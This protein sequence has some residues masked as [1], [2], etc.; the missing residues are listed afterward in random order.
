MFIQWYKIITLSAILYVCNCLTNI[1]EKGWD[2]KF[3]YL[4]ALAA[5]PYIVGGYIY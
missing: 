5:V 4:V 3:M 1:L 2:P